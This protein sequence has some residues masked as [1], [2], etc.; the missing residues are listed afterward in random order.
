MAALTAKMPKV[1]ATDP[2]R[3]VGKNKFEAL[4]E[5]LPEDNGHG[6]Q[7]SVVP[8]VSTLTMAANFLSELCDEGLLDSSPLVHCA[9]S[10]RQ[11]TWTVIKLPIALISSQRGA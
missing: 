8:L 11:Y 6:D 4:E 9:A 5:L 7:A 10:A 1:V 2:P 3:F